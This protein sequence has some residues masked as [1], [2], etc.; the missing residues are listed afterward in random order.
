MPGGASSLNETYR[1]WRV[2]CVQDGS[3]KR[4]A[5]SQVQ[6]QQNGQR[7][8]AIELNAPSVDTVSGTLVLP[9]GLAL[10]PGVTFQIDDRPAMQ[11]V[12]F[13]TCVPVG[14]LVSVIFDAPTLVAL[15]AGAA[16]KVKTVADG[17]AAA[18]FSISLQGFGTALDRVETL[19][20]WSKPQTADRFRDALHARLVSAASQ[21][22]SGCVLGTNDGRDCFSCNFGMTLTCPPGWVSLDFEET[23]IMKI[24]SR[25]RSVA[26]AVIAAAGISFA[27]S[28]H[29]DSGKISF[30]VYKAAFFVGGSGGEGTLTFHG[31][32][33]PIS[34][35]GISGGLAFG[36]SKTNFHGTVRHIRRARDVTGVYGAAGGGGALG[37][38]AQM[39]VMTNDKGAQLELSGKQVGLQVN[40]DLSGI[41]ITVK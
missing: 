2:A 1:D 22:D 16:L 34:V 36:A 6:A 4:C 40:A 38:G 9:F 31:H 20:N 25:F 24:S 3:T 15:R 37:K 13:H 29:A 28:A 23:R 8:L 33:Y 30:S 27:G 17:G 12:H 7:L 18:P 21:P 11:P 39:I 14:C 41:A 19:E 5:L 10:E 35:G 32:R 26:V